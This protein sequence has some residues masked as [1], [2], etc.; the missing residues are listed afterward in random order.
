MRRFKKLNKLIVKGSGITILRMESENTAYFLSWRRRYSKQLVM[1]HI[2]IKSVQ[3][4]K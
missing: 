2:N 3:S 1:R 4:K